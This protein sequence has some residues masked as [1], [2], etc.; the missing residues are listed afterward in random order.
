LSENWSG[1]QLG[2][3][4]YNVDRIKRSGLSG[5]KKNQTVGALNVIQS[6]IG[7]EWLQKGAEEGH[8]IF[9]YWMS[10]FALDFT[11]DWLIDFARKLDALRP[12][13]GFK[14]LLG[15]IRSAEWYPF[16][17][18][19]LDLASRMVLNGY[20]LELEPDIERRKADLKLNTA[21]GPLYMEVKSLQSPN[22]EIESKEYQAWGYRLTGDFAPGLHG[23]IHKSL[24]DKH[25]E[26]IG[27]M[28]LA[29]AKVAKDTG[30]PQEVNEDRVI[31][32][33]IE[34]DPSPTS[35]HLLKWLSQRNLNFGFHGPNFDAAER[36]HRIRRVI[37]DAKEQ[38]PKD[39]PGI[40]VVYPHRLIQLYQEGP[41]GI[42]ADPFE[43]DL[44]SQ[45][46]II[47]GVLIDKYL[48]TQPNMRD[49]IVTESNYVLL[50]QI[51]YGG[52]YENSLVIK[53]KFSDFQSLLM[54]PEVLFLRAK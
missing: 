51:F 48:L 36:V 34:T 40:I 28:I 47:A 43:E 14:Y 27:E 32:A 15:R 41:L 22:D 54:R 3:W 7:E 35:E 50:K 4:G 1:K 33:I 13:K 11:A 24:S 44:Y 38:L 42:I 39:H 25:R 29:A 52:L 19:E 49:E 46:N 5:A 37:N 45:D 8:P 26:Q 18:G 20:S 31:T 16:A 17:E 2:D 10:S 53:N 21:K 9:S 30:V 12:I 6:Y 23:Q